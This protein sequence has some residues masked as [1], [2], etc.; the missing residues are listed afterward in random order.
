MI[1]SSIFRGALL[2]VATTVTGLALA[3]CSSESANPISKTTSSVSKEAKNT[4]TTGS[5]GLALKLANGANLKEVS[6]TVSGPALATPVTGVIP[7]ESD[8]ATVSAFIGQLPPGDYQISLSGAADDNK[9]TCLGS[10]TF[11]ILAAQTTGVT[12]P[13]ICSSPEARGDAVVNSTINQCPV[14]TSVVV[15]PL[16]NQDGFPT[17]VKATASDSD[18]GDVVTFSWSSG[19]GSFAANT[20]AVTTYRCPAA[21]TT[22]V[23]TVTVSDGKNCTATESIQVTCKT[24]SV[25]G[26]NI[27][28]AGEDCDGTATPAGQ[29]CTT[30]ASPVGCRLIVCGD[31]RV[32]GPAVGGTEQC[33]KGG[34]A[35]GTATC[36]ASCQ[37]RPA[38]CGD[39]F[40]TSPEVCDP[41][42][43]PSNPTNCDVV[44]CTTKA[45][46]PPVCGDGV[47]NGTEECDFADPA[48]AAGSCSTLC[49][50]V[51]VATPCSTCTTANCAPLQS[52]CDSF[53]PGCAAL[54]Q[55]IVT[56]N[57]AK[58]SLLGGGQECYC[59]TVDN[60][61][62]FSTTNPAV[63]NGPCKSLIEA[64]AA[65]ANNNPSLIADVLF[66]QSKAHGAGMDLTRCQI[67]SCDKSCGLC[68]V[69]AN[70]FGN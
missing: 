67:S 35:S 30:G 39:N 45:P 23:I 7:V 4:S 55:C 34:A 26:N 60:D 38:L 64:S 49:K 66:D 11:T 36:T 10:A 54:R 20:Q 46:P 41:T 32:D 2:A 37:T 19:L 47:K 62:C 43:A 52:L 3:G 42:V 24:A 15:A 25:C 31:T 12:V 8:L 58:D 13:L 69:P 1:K 28:E 61:T 18:V 68:S 59:G 21:N 29:A 48:Q 50:N 70:C 33:D 5:I 40:L 27:K 14:L 16:V 53:T 63:P 6:F 65:V 51:I 44:T 22:D 57:C 9:T 56:S 17:N